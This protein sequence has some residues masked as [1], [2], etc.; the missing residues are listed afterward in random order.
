K[1]MSNDTIINVL[2]LR[3]RE[4]GTEVPVHTDQGGVAPTATQHVCDFCFA[5]MEVAYDHEAIAARVSH[6]AIA[7]GP[8]SMWRYEALLPVLSADRSTRVDMGTGLS[9]LRRAP[10]LGRALGLDDLW[11]KDDTRNPSG[12][13]K[14]RVVTIAIS[15]ARALGIDTIACASTGNLANAV[16]AHAAFAGMPAYVFIPHDLERGKVVGSAIYGANVVSVKGN[17][18]DVNRLCAEVADDQGWGFA[19]VNLRPFYA[20]GSKSIGFEIAEQL[21]WTLPDHVVIPVASGS[22][23]TK[24]DKAFGELR[25]YGLIASDASARISGAQATGCS[26]IAQAYE[27]GTFDVQPV[28]PDTIARS[29]AIGNPADGYYALKV[30]DQTD[31]AMSHASDDEIVEGMKLLASTEGLFAETAG[32]VT[33]AGLEK[34]VEAGDIA[35][36]ERVVAIISGNGYKTIEAVQAHVGPRFEVTPALEDF[37]TQLASG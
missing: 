37:T 20:E 28:K 26:P 19:N 11:L 34:L 18:D 5:P 9:P 7:A 23:L 25:A 3:C 16:A 27:Q 21:G 10:N 36:D 13:F 17:Y 32:G 15:A 2:G 24:V 30:V 8:A 29:L 33:V 6:D 4:C 31:G 12:S 35:R 1:N 14:D 22:M